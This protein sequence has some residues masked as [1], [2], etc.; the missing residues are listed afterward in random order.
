MTPSVEH[1]NLAQNVPNTCIKCFSAETN[2]KKNYPVK[3]LMP[4]A[5]LHILQLWDMVK[6]KISSVKKNNY[7]QMLLNILFKP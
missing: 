3:L 2:C 5:K 4:P 6:I 1:F 7:T